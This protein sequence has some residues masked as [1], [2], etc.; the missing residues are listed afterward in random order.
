MNDRVPGVPEE[1]IERDLLDA[2]TVPEPAPDLADRFFTRLRDA[3]SPPRRRRRWRIA[4][5]GLALALAV[6]AVLLILADRDQEPSAGALTATRRTTIEIAGRAV[7]VA[8][9]AATLAWHA[10]GDGAVRLEQAAGDIFYRVD[11]GGAFVVATRAGEVAVTGTCFRVDVPPDAAA[12]VTVHVH[13]GAVRLASAQGALELS[14]GQRGSLAPDRAPAL[15]TAPPTPAVSELIARDA[16]QKR[17]IAALEAKV[18]R[19][20]PFRGVGGTEAHNVRRPADMSGDELEAMARTCELPFDLVPLPGSTLMDKVIDEGGAKAKLTESERAALDAVLR[21]YRPG[22]ETALRAL[23][24]ELTGADGDALD[25]LTLALEIMQ[26]APAAELAAA[27]K[28]IA[29]ERAGLRAPPPDAAAGPVIERYLRFAI[30]APDEFERALA[31]AIGA[32]RARAFRRTWA[33]ADLG[34]GCA[35]D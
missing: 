6:G 11:S 15:A 2:Y 23:Y 20:E 9:P 27:K 10:S 12:P 1:R 33:S 3:D 35:Q 16:D 22:H 30:A 14:A 21:D 32:D 24:A 17:R 19:E 25:P 13:E 31:G 28:T 4:L 7:A 34:A 5:G 8:E 18:A 29:G 26:K